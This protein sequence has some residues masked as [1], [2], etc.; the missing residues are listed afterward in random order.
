MVDKANSV[1]ATVGKYKKDF[2]E[3]KGKYSK[4]TLI[5]EGFIQNVVGRDIWLKIMKGINLC[6]PHD[7]PMVERPKDITQRNEINI[8]RVS[9][10][11]V[12]DLG[13]DW[14]NGVKSYDKPLA[15]LMGPQGGAAAGLPPGPGDAAAAN[16]GP[17]APTPVATPPG[18]PN[19][20]PPAGAAPTATTPPAGD[21]AAPTAPAAPAEP[22]KGPGWVFE[23]KGYHYHNPRN[24]PSDMGPAFVARRLLKNLQQDEIPLPVEERFPGGP[25]AFPLKK[26][27]IGHAIL[28][29]DKNVDWQYKLEVDDYDD[30]SKTDDKKS[31]NEKKGKPT[32]RPTTNAGPTGFGSGADRGKK[33]MI[34]APRY[35]FTVQFCW[36]V[37]PPDTMVELTQLYPSA[38]VAGNGAAAPAAAASVEAAGMPADE[39]ADGDTSE[40][41]MDGDETEEGDTAA[42]DQAVPAGN[43]KEGQ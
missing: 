37:P 34:D 35:E 7:P 10:K 1:V 13:N 42:P 33:K 9:C 31:D 16:G 20:A 30:D 36:Q 8:E 22:P 11:Y 14:W 27:G 25:T 6:L 43:A 19:A 32:A 23:L 3:A 21:A 5:G 18:A 24:N 28:I 17:N 29:T 26:L 41:D 15:D 40:P 2:D 4:T 38:A 12:E 39:T